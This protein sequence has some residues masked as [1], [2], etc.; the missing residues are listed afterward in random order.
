MSSKNK[1]E[2]KS[3]RRSLRAAVVPVERTP[4]SPI[5]QKTSARLLSNPKQKMTG[6]TRRRLQKSR[7]VA[8]DYIFQNIRTVSLLPEVKVALK[9]E[10]LPIVKLF[11]R[12]HQ[13]C[14]RAATCR[15]ILAKIHPGSKFIASLN[16]EQT[17]QLSLCKQISAEITVRNHNTNS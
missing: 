8:L 3:A 7:G 1:I 17:H 14:R 9:L 13:A 2:N 4:V 15:Y 5:A 11:R 6:N 10:A 16:A 12:L